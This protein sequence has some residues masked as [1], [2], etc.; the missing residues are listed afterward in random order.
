MT[1]PRRLLTASSSTVRLRRHRPD[2]EAA[3]R[4]LLEQMLVLF[5]DERDYARSLQEQRRL[6]F[7][8]LAVSGSVLGALPLALARGLSGVL[9]SLDDTYLAIIAAAVAICV[10]LLI[11]AAWYLFTDR[12][13]LTASL[14]RAIVVRVVESPIAYTR[15][16]IAEKPYFRLP[17]RDSDQLADTDRPGRANRALF[18]SPEEVDQLAVL[19]PSAALWVQIESLRNAYLQLQ[20]SNRRIRHRTI[21]AAHRI[22]FAYVAVIVAIMTL[23]VGAVLEGGIR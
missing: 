4:V 8:T 10:V 11:I 14:V 13:F 15:Y 2:I 21:C 23:M 9:G 16:Q 3:R 17:V 6:H 19:G 1:T 5:N 18:L 12:S 7:A 20:A 22:F